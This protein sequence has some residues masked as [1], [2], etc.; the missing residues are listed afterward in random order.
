MIFYVL[1]SNLYPYEVKLIIENIPDDIQLT[2]SKW[3]I[4][5]KEN[6]G[7]FHYNAYYPIK[8]DYCLKLEFPNIASD[9]NINSM[10]ENTKEY[11]LAN[12]PYKQNDLDELVNKTVKLF[13]LKKIDRASVDTRSFIVNSNDIKLDNKTIVLLNNL[14][15]ITWHSGAENVTGKKDERNSVIVGYNSNNE[16][17]YI[18]E[19]SK[20]TYIENI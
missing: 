1:G 11:Y 7:E 2:D 12:H 14:K 15:M 4:S 18:T 8:K 6:Y 19:Y 17:I 9:G 16:R 20:D 13:S 5:K 3:E 10:N